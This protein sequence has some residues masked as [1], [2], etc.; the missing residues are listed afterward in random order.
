MLHE[1][2]SAACIPAVSM[3]YMSLLIMLAGVGAAS[4]GSVAVPGPRTLLVTINYLPMMSSAHAELRCCRA[5]LG[6]VRKG[7]ILIYIFEYTK[8]W[9]EL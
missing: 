8:Q 4:S 6:T 9:T 5:V 7:N 3:Q 2:S 1:T